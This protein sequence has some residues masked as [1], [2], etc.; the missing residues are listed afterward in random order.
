MFSNNKPCLCS[1]SELWKQENSTLSLLFSPC[2][3]AGCEQ[4]MLLMAQELV[5]AVP[6]FPIFHQPPPNALHALCL[7]PFRF[8]IDF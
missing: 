5:T 7:P 3:P 2:V 8:K 1:V 6:M 4:S